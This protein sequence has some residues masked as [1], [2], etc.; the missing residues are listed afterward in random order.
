MKKL[1]ILSVCLF[2]II[3]VEA[4]DKKFRAGF[5]LSPF[6]S[7]MKTDQKTIESAGSRVGLNLASSGEYYFTENLAVRLGLGLSFGQGGTLKHNEIPVGQFTNLFP[8][9]GLSS[10]SL[11]SI[12]RGTDIGYR[13]NYLEIP[14]ALKMQTNVYGQFRYF[15]EIPSF[16]LGFRT[17]AK[18]NIGGSSGENITKDT[19]L[20]NL[21]WGVGVGTIYN[22]SGDTDIVGGLYYQSG[23]TDV[24]GDSGTDKSKGTPHRIVLRI[25]VLF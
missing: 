15:A 4:Q 21:S 5:E 6:V 14:F 22:I 1:L 20:I 11:D 19:G 3:R 9:S 7:W 23:F 25:G 10:P 13:L 24:T 2:S 16:T 8:D 17:G 18:A 12:T